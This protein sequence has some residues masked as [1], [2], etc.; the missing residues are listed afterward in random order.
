MTQLSRGFPVHR[1]VCLGHS[2]TYVSVFEQYSSASQFWK[3]LT[4]F[5]REFAFEFSLE[6]DARRPTI[7]YICN[8]SRC[9]RMLKPRKFCQLIYLWRLCARRCKTIYRTSRLRMNASKTTSGK[10]THQ[11]ADS[12]GEQSFEVIANRALELLG[13]EKGQYEQ[14][15]SSRA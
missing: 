15:V 10:T 14:R 7:S 13:H 11:V 8:Y 1:F 12:C 9:P 3:P 6:I 5:I 2:T 4:R